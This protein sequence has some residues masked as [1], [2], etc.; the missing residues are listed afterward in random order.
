MKKII[1]GDNIERESTL[2][3]DRPWNMC[4]ETTSLSSLINKAFLII[5]RTFL[6]NNAQRG[7]NMALVKKQNVDVASTQLS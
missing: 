7:L 2:T 5:I 1:W 4:C 6:V 3:H